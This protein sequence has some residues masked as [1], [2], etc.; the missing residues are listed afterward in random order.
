MSASIRAASWRIRGKIGL[1]GGIKLDFSK[2][3]PYDKKYFFLIAKYIQKAHNGIAF[4]LDYIRKSTLTVKAGRS[5][6][7]AIDGFNCG[8]VYTHAH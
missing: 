4:E 3:I 6:E 2:N 1:I 7:K 5:N 8:Y